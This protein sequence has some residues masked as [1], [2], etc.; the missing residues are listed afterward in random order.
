GDGHCATTGDAPPGADQEG[1]ARV[2][3]RARGRDGIGMSRWL[4]RV[5]LVAATLACAWL[6]ASRLTL[7]SDL[8][9]LFPESGDA[10]ALVRF[11]HA[12]GGRDPAIILV[13]GENTVDVAAVADSIAGSLRSAPSIARVLDRAP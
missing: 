1:G 11:M 13:R 9:T 12:F 8:S 10:G 2:G 3:G 7:S 6:T 5:A 4:A